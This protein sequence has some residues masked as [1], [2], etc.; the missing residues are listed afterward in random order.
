MENIYYLIY[1]HSNCI[2]GISLNK[3]NNNVSITTELFDF[4]ETKNNEPGN[5]LDID[6]NYWAKQLEFFLD[7][8]KWRDHPITFI[9]P[10]EEIIFR[11]I[12]FPFQ[13]RK[14]VEQALPFELEEE[15]IFDLSEY[16]YST[17]VQPLT[18][19][20]SEALILLMDSNRLKNIQKIC[21]DRDLLIRNVDSSAYALFRSKIFNNSTQNISNDIFQ[22]YLG[23]D[24]TFVNTIINGRLEEIKI[25]PNR[26]S[27]ILQKYFAKNETSLP[28][29][30]KKFSKDPDIENHSEKNSIEVDTFSQLKE[31][32]Q[33]LCSQLTLH[34]RIKNFRPENQI[35]TY[36]VFGTLIKWDGVVFRKR[37]FPLPEAETFANRYKNNPIF[38]ESSEINTNIEESGFQD[39][40]EQPP[41]TLQEL[42]EEAK[43]RE[44]SKEEPFLTTH[45]Q[46]LNSSEVDSENLT[47]DSSLEAVNPQ[48]SILSMI[49]RKHWGIL[50]D[51]RKHAE[52]FLEPHL[53]SL[54][55][56]ST[57]WRIFFR[58]NKLNFILAAS[59]FIII[60][61]SFLWE[62]VTKFNLLKEEVVR[63]ELLIKSEIKKA[64]P[65]TSSNKVNKILKELREKINNRKFAIQ[66]SKQFEKREYKNLHFLKNISNLLD[67]N[68]SF[69]VDSLESAPERFT[70]S[71]TIDSYDNLQIFKKELQEMNEFEGK[72]ILESNRKSPDGIV[73]RILIELK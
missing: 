70:I 7:Q 60:G 55:H 48:T 58:K 39:K 27:G 40:N 1:I 68:S 19:Q 33:W 17:K 6:P 4:Y 10:S 54:Y 9:I 21:I 59:I 37:P 56:E 34:L 53:L 36:G 71:G 45:E 63:A 22:I 24:E 49:E 29:F 23:S 47:K 15:L 8:Q 44:K 28:I 25:F 46:D 61:L 3:N 30:L 20:R 52:I 43:Q 12:N 31:E 66:T 72:R 11:K 69:Q 50:G 65:K 38:N 51:L 14:K 64:L 16:I 2:E 73:Y 35:E 57:P 32:I 26:I 42:M 13:D 18:E 5:K 41:N 67:E 62:K